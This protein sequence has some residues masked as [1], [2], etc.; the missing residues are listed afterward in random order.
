MIILGFSAFIT[1]EQEEDFY[2]SENNNLH[3]KHL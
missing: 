3:D 2:I 1:S